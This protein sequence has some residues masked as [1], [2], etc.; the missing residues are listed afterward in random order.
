MPCALK[1]TAGFIVG[2]VTG[3]YVVE[4]VHSAPVTHCEQAVRHN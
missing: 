2:E 4:P 1:F 3:H